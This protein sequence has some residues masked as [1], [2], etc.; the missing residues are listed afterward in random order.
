MRPA[1]VME[2]IGGDGYSY[3]VEYSGQTLQLFTQPRGDGVSDLRPGEL[4][5]ARDVCV[6]GEL[7]LPPQQ[8]Q[9][10]W[11]SPGFWYDGDGEQVA[12]GELWVVR[13]DMVSK[14]WTAG[15]DEY[16]SHLFWTELTETLY[17]C[18]YYEPTAN[19]RVYSVDRSAGTASLV[20]NY[21]DG[22]NPGEIIMDSA[23]VGDYIYLHY[24]AYLGDPYS[25]VRR[26]DPV[27][28]TWAEVL[29][30]FDDK[31]SQGYAGGIA[32][33]ADNK[34]VASDGSNVYR[35]ATGDDGDWDFD[36][37]ITSFGNAFDSFDLCTN[38]DDGYIYGCQNDPDGAGD[39]AI[40]VRTADGTWANSLV[41]DVRNDGMTSLC[42]EYDSTGTGVAMYAQRW[43]FFDASPGPEIWRKPAGGGAWAQ[44]WAGP[45]NTYAGTYSQ[46]IVFCRGSIFTL[47]Y[48]DSEEEV[49][50][51]RRVEAGV[52]RVVKKWKPNYFL[53]QTHAS[54]GAMCAAPNSLTKTHEA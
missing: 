41:E 12:Y 32:V 1:I 7:F 19:M 11:V 49:V 5:L 44:D 14:V 3:R 8:G 25:G 23:E 20:V 27:A 15:A 29:N 36:F 42:N 6:A 24:N 54:A 47:V 13:G 9:E 33:A 37:D 43:S 39:P 38:L 22:G 4:V 35:S 31:G 50:L 45:A 16:V 51:Y 46:G 48:D 34:L 26:F 10:L 17:M 18:T 30:Y 2:D 52:M 53:F 40:I 21:G 28:E